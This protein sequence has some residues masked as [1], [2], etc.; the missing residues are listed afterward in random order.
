MHIRAHSIIEAN[1]GLHKP[2][3]CVSYSVVHVRSHLVTSKIKQAYTVS[4]V[5]SMSVL[6]VIHK[7]IVGVVL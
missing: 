3:V 2:I 7:D 1:L 5:A 6:V 4:T